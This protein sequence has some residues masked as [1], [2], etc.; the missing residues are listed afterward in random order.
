[1]SYPLS[2]DEIDEAALRKEITRRQGLRKRGLCDYCERRPRTKSCK[3]PERHR[4]AGR[5]EGDA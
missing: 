1:M 4:D 2:L 5:R 3:F